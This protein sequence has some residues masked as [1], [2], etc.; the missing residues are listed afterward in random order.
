MPDKIITFHLK[1]KSDI[2]TQ[3]QSYYTVAIMVFGN[4]YRNKHNI[5]Q[6]QDN[7]YHKGGNRYEYYT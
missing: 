4:K 1:R 3:T 7:S 5:N 6:S 2:P